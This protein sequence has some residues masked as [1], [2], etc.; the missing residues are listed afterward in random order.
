[1][2]ASFTW[3]PV[4]L[5]FSFGL[6]EA[7]AN[8]YTALHELLGPL[9]IKVLV[10][11]EHGLTTHLVAKKR[12]TPKGLQALI[13]GKFIVHNDSF[14]KAIVAAATPVSPTE[15]GAVA[16]SE[17]ARL[18]SPAWRGADRK[19]RLSIRSGSEPSRYF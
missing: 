15:E 17:L 16:K 5:T 8:P 9:D 11:Y 1:M 3:I 2:H 7:K 19:G 18:S 6:K 12:N 10:E 14:I 4:T 13:E